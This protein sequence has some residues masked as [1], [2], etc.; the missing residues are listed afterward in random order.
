MIAQGSL[1][2]LLVGDYSGVHVTLRN[3]L[4]K[5]GHQVVLVSDGDGY[6]K[7]SRDL[8]FSVP[9][10]ST[11]RFGVF[12]G[13]V[14][15]FFG[16][17][18]ISLLWANRGLLSS[19]KGYDVVQLINPVPFSGLGS[20]ASIIFFFWLKIS[21]K[22]IVL[23]ALGDDYYWVDAS[24]RGEYRY[25]MFDRMKF[26]NSKKFLHSLRYKYF[27]FY[28]LANYL[29]LSNSSLVICGLYDYYVAYNFTDRK[30]RFIPLPVDEALLGGEIRLTRYPVKIF[31][32][33]QRGKELRKGNDIFHAAVARLVEKYG[34]GVVEYRI[35]QSVPFEEYI[36]LYSDA[37]IFLDQ[38]YSYDKGMN[39]LL[40]MAA[41]KVVFTGWEPEAACLYSAG[42]VAPCINALPDVDKV[43]FILERLVLDL[44]EVDR[45]KRSAVDFVATN[46]LSL[47]VAERYLREWMDG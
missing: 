31:H 16:L 8:S 34:E 38:A 45:I 30:R 13:V 37:D 27:L 20:I 21:N 11:G 14:I 18:G 9:K 36:S 4:L 3:A 12:L 1:K 24:L 42:S 2:I 17:S 32:G 41:G 35:V 40:G 46:H 28:R 15:S 26:L 19:L 47:S 43:Y 29:M 23:C 7:F 33:W 25:S 22:K 5:L 6:K 10:S 44:D 39:G